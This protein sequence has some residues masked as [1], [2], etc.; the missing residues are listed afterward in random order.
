[1]NITKIFALMMLP[2]VVATTSCSSGQSAQGTEADH[3]VILHTNDTH[4]SI[5]P[6]RKDRGGIARRKVLV[7]SVRQARENV[8][9][10]DA[11]DAVQGSLY[12]TLFGG[13]VE[14][15]LMNDLGYDIQI[16]GNHEFDKGMES[17][18]K[19]WKQVKATRLSTNYDLKGS[20]L[21]GLFVPSVVKEFNGHKVGFIGIN[22]DPQGIIAGPNYEGVKYIDAVEAA[23]AEAAKLKSEGVETVIAV[24]HIGY[25]NDN[26]YSDLKLAAASK[27]IDVI[28]GGHSHTT[29][30]PQST[31]LDALPWR[32]ANAEG[33]T[34]SVLQTGYGGVNLG[35]I[36]INLAN[37]KVEARL[38][39]VDS[40]LDGRVDPAFT[41]II[42]GYKHSV[43]SVRGLVVGKTAYAFE[44]NSPEI[45][46]LM[47]DFVFEAGSEIAGKPVD[48]A[49]MNKGGIRNSLA[50]G[51]VTKGEIIDIAPFDNSIVI[52]DIL[53]SDLLENLGIMAA[54]GGNGV[55]G[56]VKVLY[57]PST[58]AIN[59]ATI[60]GKPIDSKRHYRLAT[61]DYLAAGNDY[62]EP[63]KRASL[64]AKS[65]NVLYLELIDRFQNGKM[66]HL[67]ANP[68]HNNRMTSF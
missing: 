8:M 29:I 39:P 30:D 26:D 44:R 61:I 43:D 54:Q 66:D 41:A 45:L 48:L 15:R 56:N 62:M 59:S 32:V 37:G 12:Y 60:N 6:D 53:G 28:I 42:D 7:D 22:L 17:L 10:I 18:A 1:M 46:N 21:D 58:Y 31:A 40:R 55:S 49:I 68:D 13:E 16:L 5:E 14:R 52:L 63:L 20:T 38:I 33:D 50:A 4:S 11:G 64:L 25:D 27:D 47:S 24:T 9:L 65:K 67:T 2:M 34:I 36:D 35:E 23:N 3:L 57:D 51:D 19:E